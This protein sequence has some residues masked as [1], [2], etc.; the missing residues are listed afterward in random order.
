MGIY[1]IC[2]CRRYRDSIFKIQRLSIQKTMP[3]AILLY[4]EYTNNVRMEL[5]EQ[6]HGFVKNV[7]KI[8]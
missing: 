8:I 6:S 3:A 2:L 7:I 1:N 5:R 4:Y